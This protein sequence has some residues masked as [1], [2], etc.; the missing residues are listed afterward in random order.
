MAEESGYK[1]SRID[2]IGQNGPTAEHY[3]KPESLTCWSCDKVTLGPDGPDG[4]GKGHDEL[5]PHAGSFDCEEF[6]REPGA[7][8]VERER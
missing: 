7:G 3:G 5:F 1:I 4:C 2:I 6:Y 8:E